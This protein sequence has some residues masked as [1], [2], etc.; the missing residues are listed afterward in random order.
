MKNHQSSALWLAWALAL[1][2]AFCFAVPAAMAADQQDQESAQTENTLEPEALEALYTM[3]S[4][5]RTLPAFEVT[6]NFYLDEVLVSGQKILVSGQSALKVKVPNKLYSKVSVDEKERNF[7]M[8]FDGQNFTLYGETHNFYATVSA[9]GTLKDLAEKTFVEKGIEL[10]LQDLF[11]W[12]TQASDQDAVTSA[13]IIGNAVLGG[14]ACT[15]Y[16]YRQEG[17][18]WQLWIQKGE[19]SLPLQVVITTTSDDSQPQYA[20]RLNW[21]LEPDVDDALFTFTPPKGAHPINFLPLAKKN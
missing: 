1:V 19:R 14:K 17:V 13:L 8:Y 20:A 3:S 4:Y 16:A 7:A 5:L 12:G 6:S 11:L 10:P 15:H 9:P 2:M 21:D 18:D